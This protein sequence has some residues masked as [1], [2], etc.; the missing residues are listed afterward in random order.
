ME[1]E[2]WR[3]GDWRMGDWRIFWGPI[4]QEVYYDE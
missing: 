4:E 3:M 1:N 2:E